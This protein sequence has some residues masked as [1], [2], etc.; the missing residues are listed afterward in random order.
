MLIASDIKVVNQWNSLTQD[1]DHFN[2]CIIDSNWLSVLNSTLEWQDTENVK[3][4]PIKI[5]WNALVNNIQVNST[6]S[7]VCILNNAFLVKYL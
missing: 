4:D 3:Y 7:V 2:Y 6:I 1:Q 5:F